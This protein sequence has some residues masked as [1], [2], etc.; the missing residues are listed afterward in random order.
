MKEIKLKVKGMMCS[1]CEKRVS[2][3]LSMIEGIKEVIVSYSKETVVIKAS[4]NVD[5][6]IIK[7]QIE[8]LG[9]EVGEE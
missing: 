7:E 5:I 2:N 1:G 4:E 9:F 6:N 8:E 3:S